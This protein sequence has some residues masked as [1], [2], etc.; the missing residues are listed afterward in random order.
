MNI[1]L[2]HAFTIRDFYYHFDGTV[3]IQYMP[4]SNKVGLLN[5][6]QNTICNRYLS[7]IV[8]NLAQH[9]YQDS[10]LFLVSSQDTN[11]LHVG[12]HS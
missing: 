6:F 10:I 12:R 7:D 5:I 9:F 3:P 11:V 8:K 4:S 2:I 1:P